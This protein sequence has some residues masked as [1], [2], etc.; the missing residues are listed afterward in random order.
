VRPQYNHPQ[1]GSM[2]K[3]I[4]VCCDGTGQKFGDRN[5]NVV[6][7]YRVLDLDDPSRQIAYYHGGLG[8]MGSPAALTVLSC[9]WTKFLG[10]AFGYGLTRDIGDAYA[11][12]MDTYMPGDRVYLFGFSRGAYTVRALSSLLYMFGLVRPENFNLIPYATELLK[13]EAKNRFE[14][15]A[16]FKETFSRSCPTHFIGVWDTVS[17]VGWITN[18]VRLPYTAHNPEIRHGRHA[19]SIDERRCFFRTNLWSQ[20]AADQDI[21]QVWFAGVHSDV[22]GGYA[23]KES[24]LSKLAFEWMLREAAAQQLQV[25]DA[26]VQEVLG[27]AGGDWSQPDPTAKLHDSLFEDGWWLLEPLPHKFTDMSVK[28]PQSRWRIPLGRRRRMP[29]GSLV[30]ASAFQRRQQDPSYK[31]SNL[32]ADAR[33]EPWTPWPP[34]AGV[35]HA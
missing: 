19:V 6:K 13:K 15:A 5:S 31:P 33:E 28:P 14:V 1:R 32:V 27:R 4:V 21:K 23:E 10:L 2:P 35:A 30:H 20:P 8:T 12:L 25:K 29:A 24:G 16:Q 26:R 18:Q 3:N 22:G 17:S 9:A 11:Y 7:L 34:A